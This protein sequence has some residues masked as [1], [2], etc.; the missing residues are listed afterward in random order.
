MDHAP[1]GVHRDGVVRFETAVELAARGDRIAK[2]HVV[3]GVTGRGV[4]V[5][6]QPLAQALHRAWRAIARA[7][8]FRQHR[9]DLGRQH[10]LPARLHVDQQDLGVAVALEVAGQADEE[11]LPVGPQVEF[12]QFR[13]AAR[14]QAVAIAEAGDRVLTGYQVGQTVTG[15]DGR[16]VDTPRGGAELGRRAGHSGEL[17]S[18]NGGEVRPEA[19][20]G[21]AVAPADARQGLVADEPGRA[22]QDRGHLDA[23]GGG[24][25]HG[26][27]KV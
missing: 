8:H 17:V 6:D 7:G 9:R 5:V 12:I 18:G 10:V 14:G 3:G 15:R 13:A 25:R 4:V 23:H 22:G 19:R 27:A 21:Q 2:G 20:I 24:Q 1:G 16:P 11:V 26:Q